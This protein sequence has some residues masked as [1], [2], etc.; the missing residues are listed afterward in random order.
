LFSSGLLTQS[1]AVID[2]VPEH[3]QHLLGRAL[4][5]VRQIDLMMVAAQ[6]QS[7]RSDEFMQ[8]H[9]VRAF[10]RVRPVVHELSATAFREPPHMDPVGNR[11]AELFAVLASAVS[12]RSADT[13]AGWRIIMG[14]SYTAAS[15]PRDAR[16]PRGRL[17]DSDKQSAC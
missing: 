3:G 11:L 5:R 2:R 7:L 12:G 17:K 14:R 16:G 4:A 13:T 15:P 9:D 1:Q 10:M 8:A 6:S